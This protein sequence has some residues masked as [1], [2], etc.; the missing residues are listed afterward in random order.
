MADLPKIDPAVAIAAIRDA[1]PPETD[2][3]TY[4]TI[5]EANLCPEILPA[6]NDIL[7]ESAELTQE[8]GWDLVFNLVNLPGSEACLETI[9]RLGNPREVVLK[10]L[11]TLELLDTPS[12][13]QEDAPTTVLPESVSREQKFVTLLGVLAIVHLRI[14]TKYPSRFLAQ[15]LRTVIQTYDPTQ[16]ATA[17]V[18]NLIHNLSGRR[19]PALP[20]RKSSINVANPAQD[21]DASKNAPDPEA[22]AEVGGKNDKDGIQEEAM[23]QKLLLSFATCVLAKYTDSNDMGWATRL[24]EFYYPEKIPPRKVTAMKLYRQ[25]EELLQRDGIIGRLVALIKDLGLDSCPKSHV[26]KLS[27]GPIVSDPLSTPDDYADPDDVALSTGG[28]ID[29]IAYWAFSATVFDADLPTPEMNILPEHLVL[30]E[31]LLGEDPES[32]IRQSPGT[33]QSLVAIGLWLHASDHI[34]ASSYKPATSPRTSDDEPSGFMQ[35]LHLITLIALYSP[36]IAWRNSAIQLAGYVFHANPSEDDR[37]H[38]LNDLLENCTFATLKAAAITWL[39]EEMIAASSNPSSSS[40][41]FSTPQAFD[42][43]QYVI[44]PPFSS[45]SET[46]IEEVIDFFTQQMHFLMQAANFGLLLWSS[47]KWEHVLPPNADATV[48]ERWFRPLYSAVERIGEL[49]NDKDAEQLGPLLFE[50]DVLQQRMVQMSE[51][52]RFRVADVTDAA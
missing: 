15:T 25:D 8:I 36:R 19:R 28:C 47:D 22:E 1:R 42:T 43:L 41:I 13:D 50:L 21:G 24:L 33:F 32:Q 23:Q 29:L 17:A 7:Q 2:R 16:E 20:N 37:L 9:A 48:K 6:L 11:E 49:K 51:S 26:D 14:K 12:S 34:S 44:F 5:I 30:L 46:P 3:F 4:L 31:K 35:Y 45:L 40:T 39:R 52:E 18:V 27:E 10:V 38:I